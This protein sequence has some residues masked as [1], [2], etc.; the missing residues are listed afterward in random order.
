M[1]DTTLR[2]IVGSV[3]IMLIVCQV[4]TIITDLTNVAGGS[5]SAAVVAVV[6]FICARRANTGIGDKAWFLVPVILFVLLPLIYKVWEFFSHETDSLTLAINLLSWLISFLL[7]VFF[8]LVIYAELRK[9]TISNKTT[10][11][12]ITTHS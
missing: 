4:G 2:Q 10:T 1:K 3:L 9:R 5:I 6:T 12:T 7:P 8:L 11:P